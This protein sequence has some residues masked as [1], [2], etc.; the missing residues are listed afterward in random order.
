MPSHSRA[1][2]NWDSSQD[3]DFY[4]ESWKFFGPVL[5]SKICLAIKEFTC[6]TMPIL[7]STELVCNIV[8]D[9]LCK[10]PLLRHRLRKKGRWKSQ[11]FQS[12][13]QH[14]LSPLFSVGAIAHCAVLT[15]ADDWQVRRKRKAAG[16]QVPCQRMP[17]LHMNLTKMSESSVLI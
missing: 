9:Q 4:L 10:Q 12:K 14:S 11:K 7:S 3:E 16:G 15:R 8:F 1:R 6:S 2:Q 5:L 17:P 13:L